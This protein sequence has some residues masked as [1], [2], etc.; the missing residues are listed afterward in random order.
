MEGERGERGGKEKN[1][2]TYFELAQL[3]DSTSFIHYDNSCEKK[4]L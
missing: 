4:K 3:Q 1:L 2:K